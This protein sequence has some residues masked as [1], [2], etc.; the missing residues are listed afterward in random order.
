MTQPQVT[1]VLKMAAQV[2][3]D[4]EVL[5]RDIN[6]HEHEIDADALPDSLWH[7]KFAMQAQRNSVKANLQAALAHQNGEVV[8]MPGCAPPVIAHPPAMEDGTPAATTAQGDLGGK[9]Q[10]RPDHLPPEKNLMRQKSKL[11]QPN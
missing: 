5:E 3:K 7:R 1:D 11:A 10:A 9:M 6:R 8:E 2:L 4:W